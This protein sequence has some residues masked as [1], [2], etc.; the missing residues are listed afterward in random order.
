MPTRDSDAQLP[1]ALSYLLAGAAVLRLLASVV[2]GFL[3]LAS[4][5]GD[6]APARERAGAILTAFGA[7]GDTVSALLL[8][9]VV[10]LLAW[11]R[12][13]PRIA[14]LVQTVRV[15]LF[16]TAVLAVL[17]MAAAPVRLPGN[18]HRCSSGC[19]CA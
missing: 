19:G 13:Q 1:E 18:R 14:F 11:G 10:A 5:R 17:R 4:D 7:A 3:T 2:A 8:L 9:G 16:V 6:F 12:A 15:L